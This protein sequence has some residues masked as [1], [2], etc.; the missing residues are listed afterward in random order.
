MESKK[1]YQEVA[2]PQS[3]LKETRLVGPAYDPESPE[4]EAAFREAEAVV[5]NELMDF[6]AEGSSGEDI[7]E[8]D[9]ENFRHAAN[10]VLANIGVELHG[11][12]QPDSTL[13]LAVVEN[14]LERIHDQKDRLAVDLEHPGEQLAHEI[15]G[16]AG[17]L[18]ELEEKEN[19][20]IRTA[21]FLY[22]IHPELTRL[23]GK[24]ELEMWM[25]DARANLVV[26]VKK[27]GDSRREAVSVQKGLLVNAIESFDRLL[28]GV[29][30]PGDFEVTTAYIRRKSD[31]I[32]QDFSKLLV[33]YAFRDEGKKKDIE[34]KIVSQEKLMFDYRQLIGLLEEEKHIA[35]L[36]KVKK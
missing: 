24:V 16:N 34:K 5:S 2:D 8:I 18:Q 21:E 36:P 23:S 4:F 7:T 35:N 12:E 27:M 11:G 32:R 20:Y 28:S 14:G 6:F 17:E 19:Q 33:D 9:Q 3:G 22:S 15:A 30:N 26:E 29:G 1:Y 13:A 31:I 10:V 25:R